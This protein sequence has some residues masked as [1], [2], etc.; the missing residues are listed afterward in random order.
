MR[1]DLPDPSL[2]VLDRA[3]AARAR[4]TFAARHFMPTEVLSS[5]FCRG[6]V[7]DDENDQA[8]TEDAFAVLHFIAARRLRRRPA[9]RRR[10]HQRAAR[11][12]RRP[13]VALA[14]E[15]DLFPVAIVLDLPEAVCRERNRDRPDRDF[16]VARDPAAALAAPALAEGACSARASGASGSCVTR[17]GRG[18]RGRRARRCGPTGEPTRAVRRHRRR[19]RVPRRARRAA[20]RARLRVAPACDPAGGPAGRVR[21]R[22]RRPRARAPRRAPARHGHGGGRDR[23]LPSRQSRH[24]ARP[25]ARGA[26]RPDHARTG[27]V[28]RAAGVR[29]TRS[30]AS[31]CASSWKVWSAMSCSTTA[32]WS[33]P[34]PGCRS[35]TRA[36][37]PVGSA[38][39]RC[40]ARRPVRPTSSGCPSGSSGRAT[41]AVAPTVVYGHTPVAEPEWLNNTINIDTGCVFGGRLTALRWPEREL[42]SV[43]ARAGPTTSPPSRSSLQGRTRSARRS[44]S[45]STTSRASASSRRV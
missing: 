4:A 32:S 16:G 37:P 6:L 19:P 5:D 7:A 10:R 9:H 31:R 24:Q 39:S 12:A 18:G 3:S 40:S 14:R 8:A 28:A 26:R 29:A 43:P 25:Q 41:T 2:V 34:T 35:A 13:L 33:S 36:A 22:L 44:C 23:D 17:R 11:G 42:V 38:T 20:R 45:T 1:I 15:H 27:R 30:S 21:R